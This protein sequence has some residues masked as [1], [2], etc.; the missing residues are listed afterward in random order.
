MGSPSRMIASMR[1]WP[2]RAAALLVRQNVLQPDNLA[3]QV[4]EVLLGRVDDRQPLLKFRQ[5]FVLV[6]LDVVSSPVPTRCW[7]PSMRSEIMRTKSLWRVPKT[8]ATVCIRPVISA[9]SG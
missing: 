3:R 5:I 7:R 6:L 1:P 8:S 4:L 9:W 2:I